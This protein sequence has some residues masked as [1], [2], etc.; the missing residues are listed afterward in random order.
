[1]TEI[2]RNTTLHFFSKEIDDSYIRTLSQ[3]FEKNEESLKDRFRCRICMDGAD[4]IDICN[5]KNRFGWSVTFHCSHCN[6]MWFLCKKCNAVDQPELPKKSIRRMR[7]HD[8]REYM[9]QEIAKHDANHRHLANTISLTNED[10]NIQEDGFVGNDPFHEEESVILDNN[11]ILQSSVLSEIRQ[12]SI[13]QDEDNRLTAEKKDNIGYALLYRH[14]SGTY[15][16]YLIKKYWVKNMSCQLMNEDCL[17]FVEMVSELLRGSRD[18]NKR[19]MNLVGKTT[20]RCQK[21]LEITSNRVK[22]LENALNKMSALHRQTLHFCNE[23]TGVDDML[24]SSLSSFQSETSHILDDINNALSGQC[25]NLA[26]VSQSNR[27]AGSVVS[28]SIR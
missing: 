22:E 27:S 25:L 4:T 11:G 21:M 28:S 1:M 16:P 19:L 18:D 7:I 26:N 24:R 9:D 5:P 6:F 2:E 8:R 17:L 14:V 3:Y 13:L 10:L 23:M 20:T 12:S 15:A